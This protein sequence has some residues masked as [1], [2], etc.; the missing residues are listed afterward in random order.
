MSYDSSTVAHSDEE[1]RRCLDI[2]LNG[3]F[4]CLRAFGKRMVEKRS[5]SIVCI[6]S[7]AGVKAVEQSG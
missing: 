6:S 5:G 4:Y 1:W 2:N 3:V 7:I